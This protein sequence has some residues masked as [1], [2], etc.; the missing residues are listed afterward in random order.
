[1]NLRPVSAADQF[2]DILSDPEHVGDDLATL[3]A[4]TIK[5]FKGIARKGFTAQDVKDPETVQGFVQGSC[6]LLDLRA[7]LKAFIDHLA[8]MSLPHGDWQGQFDMDKQAFAQQFK[9]LYGGV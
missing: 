6:V 9:K 8:V 2:M 5:A 1:M 4:D 3:M 7:H